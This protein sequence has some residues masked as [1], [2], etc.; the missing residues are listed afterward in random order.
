MFFAE[1]ITKFTE[2][3]RSGHNGAVLKTVKVQAYGGS[4]PS[5]S[6]KSKIRINLRASNLIGS[7]LFLYDS[8]GIEFIQ[9]IPMYLCEIILS[10]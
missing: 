1:I 4:S 2:A 8:A 7:V 5:A 10:P 6:A 9:V 3:Y